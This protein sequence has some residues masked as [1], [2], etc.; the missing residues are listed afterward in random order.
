M[1][2]IQLGMNQRG[3]INPDGRRSIISVKLASD[4]QYMARHGL[5]L[6]EKYQGNT[7]AVKANIPSKS[8]KLEESNLM[9]Q[10]GI[11]PNE[12]KGQAKEESGEVELELPAQPAIDS[13]PELNPEPVQPVKKKGAK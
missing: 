11:S 6:L 2:E 5:Q 7:V 8:N 12:L 3:V 9:Q 13:E 4:P 1:S 10:L